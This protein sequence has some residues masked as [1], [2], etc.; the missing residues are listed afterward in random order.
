MS[1]LNSSNE[2]ARAR[3]MRGIQINI[4]VIASG[5]PDQLPSHFSYIYG[6]K[7]LLGLIPQGFLFL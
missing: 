5:V 1:C 2:N 3:K 4:L 6:S 7:S